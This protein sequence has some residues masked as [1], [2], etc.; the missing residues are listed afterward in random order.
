MQ[1]NKI[2]NIFWMIPCLMLGLSSFFFVSCDDDDISGSVVDMPV[3]DMWDTTAIGK[4]IYEN[5][6]LPF[7][8]RVIYRWED[9]RQDMG[10][11][12]VPAKE[13]K[14]VPFLSMLKR[15]WMDPYVNITTA[16]GNPDFLRTYVPK[17]IL[18]TGSKAI[19]SDGSVTLG[20]AES[21]RQ[22]QLYDVNNL[23]VDNRDDFVM[24]FHTMHHEF[25]HI[26]QQT[27]KDYDTEYR[28]LTKGGY[29]S[30]WMN[31]TNDAAREEG[32][33]TAYAKS[34][35]DEDFVEMLSIM[36]VNSPNAWN[37]LIDRIPSESARNILREKERLMIEWM[38]DVWEIDMYK[39]Q[40][41]VYTAIEAEM[42]LSDDIDLIHDGNYIIGEMD[43]NGNVTLY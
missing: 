29:T 19:N 26:L 24:F 12:L 15:V 20:F 4:Y 18:V 21:G 6:T 40:Q 36:L 13:E 2:N 35:V 14:I 32:F 9:N 11:Y 16:A 23:S 28:V 8:I 5:Y 22:I 31:T 43:A 38:K 27:N 39:F 7:N 17:E 37:Y 10:K 41:Q 3:T 25:A 1:K 33:I 42:E 30:S 34:S